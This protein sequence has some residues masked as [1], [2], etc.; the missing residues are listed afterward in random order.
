MNIAAG[1]GI[2]SQ[3]VCDRSARC[4]VSA[5]RHCDGPA[6]SRPND[7]AQCGCVDAVRFRQATIHSCS[8]AGSALMQV[9]D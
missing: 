9:P 6:G 3:S 7:S 1:E 5:S 4:V 8:R 2:G